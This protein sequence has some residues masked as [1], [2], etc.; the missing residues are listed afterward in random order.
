[1][2]KTDFDH[3]VRAAA[4]V[5]GTDEVL[6]IGSQAIHASIPGSVPPEAERSVEVDIAVIGDDGSKADLIDG[7][8]GEASI[9]HE[10]FGYYAKGV[11][12]ATVVLPSGWRQRLIRYRSPNNPGMVA[13]CLEPHDL[14]IAK[15]I[16]HRPKDLEFCGAILKS[17]VVTGDLLASR[18][19]A[20]DGLEASP[21]RR[22]SRSDRLRTTISIG[23]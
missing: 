15:A 8:I 23:P 2:N 18:L 20:V 11:T 5:L 22:Y 13:L 10:T 14:W 7:S 16:A 9:F 1:M 6:V 19:R 4:A 3:A 17:G 12:E 21:R